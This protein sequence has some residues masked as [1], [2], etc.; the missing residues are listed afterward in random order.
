MRSPTFHI[1]L[2]WGV[3]LRRKQVFKGPSNKNELQNVVITRTVD[4]IK[5][6]HNHWLQKIKLDAR[7]SMTG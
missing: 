3:A 7:K 5:S 6:I 4:Y 1:K 2:F